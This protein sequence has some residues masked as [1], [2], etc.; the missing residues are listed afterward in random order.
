MKAKYLIRMDDACP[1]MHQNWETIEAILTKYHIKPVVAVIPNNE[2]QSLVFESPR[3]NF[4]DIIRRW[5]ALG[6]DIALH[7][8]NHVY[9]NA[10]RGM[11]GIGNK[12]EFAG[13][14]LEEQQH[15]IEKGIAIF[16]QEKITAAC[17]V[18][19]SHSFDRTTLQA[20]QTKSNIRIISDGLALHP[21]QQFNFKWIPQQLWSFRTMPFGT[22]TFC[23]HPNTMKPKDI[24]ALEIFLSKH[25][26]SFTNLASIRHYS[27][28]NFVDHFFRLL[29]LYLLKRKHVQ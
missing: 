25:A 29:F 15:K 26:S 6:W 1:T 13:L 16:N 7:G 23:V 14:P 17:W 18:A 3:N 4:W 24:E 27:G 2:D 9:T 8:Y 11:V 22:W 20:L 5:Q 21:F 10:E 12:S 19:P 28:L